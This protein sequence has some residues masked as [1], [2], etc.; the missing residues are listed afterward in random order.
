MGNYTAWGW[1]WRCTP[2]TT[3]ASC[4]RSAS[5]ATA[6]WRRIG[7]N[8]RSSWPS[9]TTWG[10]AKARHGRQ[11]GRCVQPG[12]HLQIRRPRPA[13]AQRQPRRQFPAL[14]A[15]RL[16]HLRQH[17]RPILL[18]PEGLAGALGHLEP[19]AAAQ[20][21]E[22]VRMN[23]PQ[24]PAGAGTGAAERA[25]S[26]RASPRATACKSKALEPIR[27]ATTCLRFVVAGAGDAPRARSPRPFVRTAGRG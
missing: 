10:G 1:R 20:Q 15:E 25:A 7:A 26:S 27:Y 9:S 3:R 6:T 11:H 21:R 16:A 4:R 17:Q 8:F 23:A 19:G 18:D 2:T 13:T 12:A 14:G 22:D 24:W 5:T